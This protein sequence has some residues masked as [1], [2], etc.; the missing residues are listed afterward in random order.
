MRLCSV[1]CMFIDVNVHFQLKKKK[2]ELSVLTTRIENLKKELSGRDAELARL[3]A[4]VSLSPDVNVLRS[5]LAEAKAISAQLSGMY[6]QKSKDFRDS[7]LKRLALLGKQIL[8]DGEAPK[9]TPP[10][11]PRPASRRGRQ[12][13]RSSGR[14]NQDSRTAPIPAPANKSTTT[15]ESPLS[16]QPFWQNEP[17]FTKH[18][19]CVTSL[20]F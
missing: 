6:E 17:L 9:T 12:R 13:S 18:H 3:R 4:E 14:D 20:T 1:Y 15:T 11:R 8:A 16:S 19:V 5:E 10:A 7:E 2:K